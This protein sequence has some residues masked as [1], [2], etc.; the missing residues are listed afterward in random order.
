MRA[1]STVSRVRSPRRLTS[2]QCTAQPTVRRGS[3]PTA[4]SGWYRLVAAEAEAPARGVVRVL[5]AAVGA[6][7]EDCVPGVIDGELSKAQCGFRL[8]ARAAISSAKRLFPGHRAIQPRYFDAQ[9]K[10]AA[11]GTQAAS[12]RLR[13]WAVGSAGRYRPG[14]AAGAS[15]SERVLAGK[16]LNQRSSQELGG[17]IA[18]DCSV[19]VI[20]IADAAVVDGGGANPRI[21]PAFEY[22]RRRPRVISGRRSRASSSSSV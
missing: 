15:A 6:H 16:L 14:S 10:F 5:D 4:T 3:R 1:R 7:G 21:G 17:G 2:L 12:F 9:G 8:A 18:V 20:G 22:A 19:A 11:V 13:W